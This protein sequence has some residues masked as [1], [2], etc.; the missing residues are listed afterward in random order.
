MYLW[1]QQIVKRK[2]LGRWFRGGGW[3]D[4]LRWRRAA[5]CAWTIDCATRAASWPSGCCNSGISHP[6]QVHGATEERN[7]ER[8][9]LVRM[10]G[11]YFARLLRMKPARPRL[12]SHNFE[13][14]P[15]E[16]QAPPTNTV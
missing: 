15:L 9:Y 14:H 3:L 2:A 6:E 4:S 10:S 11:T 12:P 13:G 8:K 7:E 5:S 1:R 16:S